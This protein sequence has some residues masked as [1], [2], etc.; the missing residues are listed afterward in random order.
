MCAVLSFPFFFFTKW[1]AVDRPVSVASPSLWHSILERCFRGLRSIQ[2]AFFTQ[3]ERQWW[4]RRRRGGLLA[5]TTIC[6]VF[7]FS[8]LLS[9]LLHSPLSRSCLSDFFHCIANADKKKPTKGGTIART[10]THTHTR[11]F[12]FHNKSFLLD[13]TQGSVKDGSSLASS[14]FFFWRT[15]VCWLFSFLFF[16]PSI[17][18]QTSLGMQQ[19]LDGGP[20]FLAISRMI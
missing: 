19:S 2:A 20:A 3:N 4:W 11:F 8:L 15:P 9:F 1:P 7:L 16:F 6:W 17:C 14:S 10:R 12:G 13:R 18:Y 5:K